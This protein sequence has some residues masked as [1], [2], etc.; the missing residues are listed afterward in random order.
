MNRVVNNGVKYSE[1]AM[2]D[3]TNPSEK[4]GNV[5]THFLQ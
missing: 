4:K 5:G 2:I 1:D 3:R